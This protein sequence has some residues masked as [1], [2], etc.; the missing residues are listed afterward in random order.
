M[1]T[2]I[3]EV[4]VSDG[5]GGSLDGFIFLIIIYNLFIL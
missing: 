5:G 1:S 4:V 3:L 2:G